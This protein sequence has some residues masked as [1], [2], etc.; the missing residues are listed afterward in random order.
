MAPF[1]PFIYVPRPQ[2]SSANIDKKDRKMAQMNE[3]I[4]TAPVS[5]SAI[6]SRNPV[7]SPG[8]ALTA[9]WCHRP[10]WRFISA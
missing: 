3:N 7:S 8:P 10:R 4:A 1:L 9:G 2:H 5:P 6:F